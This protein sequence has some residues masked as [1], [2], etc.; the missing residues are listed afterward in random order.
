MNIHERFV[1]VNDE[2]IFLRHSDIRAD[3]P[4]LLF[5]HGLGESG[6]CFVEAFSCGLFE[7][8]NL[9]VPDQVGYG[10]SSRASNGDYSFAAQIGRLREMISTLAVGDV[11]LIGHSLGGI[12]G[13]LWAGRKDHPPIRRLVNVEGNLTDADATFSRRAA[14]AFESLRRDFG[15]WCVWF[16]SEFTQQ[17]VF[18]Q[19]ESRFSL[20]RYY[21]S[22]LFARPKAFLANALEIIERS[23]TD[24]GEGVSEI[25]HAYR[26]L[27]IPKI[28]LW[29][30]ESLPEETLVFLEREGLRNR[31]FQGAGHWPMIDAADEFYPAL[32][33]FLSTTGEV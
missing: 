24:Q 19:L 11:T 20:K 29:G 17:Q 13:T 7:G 4:T 18:S 30:K 1:Q 3:R 21:A 31:G 26:T 22:L 28:Y 15:R 27:E 2:L 8:F 9:I 23:R 16:L 25:G 12:L 5:V 10:R 14:V 6:L 32:A 33:E